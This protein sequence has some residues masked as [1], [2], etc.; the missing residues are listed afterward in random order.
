MIFKY[1]K[2]RRKP[3]TFRA[4]T[5]LTP[6]EFD[7]YIEPLVLALAR[8]ERERLELDNRRRVIG[9]GRHHD[10]HWRDQF[11]LTLV[12]C[13]CTRPMRSWATSSASSDTSAHRNGTT[14]FTLL[15]NDWSP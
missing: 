7:E 15:R 12:W 8:Q 9:G 3:A 13:A 1:K 11:L 4:V 10:L 6:D 14:L 5:G 2:L